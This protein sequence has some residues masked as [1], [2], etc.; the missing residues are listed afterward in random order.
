MIASAS[1]DEAHAALTWVAAALLSALAHAVVVLLILRT[2]TARPEHP[3][4]AAATD[5]ELIDWLAGPS[6][7]AVPAVSAVTAVSAVLAHKG[8][9][10]RRS[11][12]SLHALRTFHAARVVPDRSVAPQVAPS[13]P[14]SQ[15]LSTSALAKPAQTAPSAQAQ[16]APL[17]GRPIIVDTP[18]ARNAL[19]LWEAAMSEQLERVKRYPEDSR[20]RHEEDTVS[21]RIT[22]NRSGQVLRVSIVHSR[23]FNLLDQEALQMVQRAAPLPPLPQELSGDR[24]NVI[25][26]VEFFLLQG[27]P[28]S[29]DAPK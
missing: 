29:S 21:L 16:L 20:Q 25:V 2:P 26:P 1:S 12:R 23:G 3:A 13:P 22:V 18:A 8:P 9:A 17:P 24:I 27:L 7:A 14:P 19:Q 6:T 5:V 28:L 4:P 11:R 10:L 15:L